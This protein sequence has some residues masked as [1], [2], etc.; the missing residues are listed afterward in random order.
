MDD[1]FIFRK[2][3]L[4]PYIEAYIS[5]ICQNLDTIYE[6]NREKCFRYAVKGQNSIQKNVELS[7][8]NANPVL[9]KFLQ[10]IKLPTISYEMTIHINPGFNRIDYNCVL[11]KICDNIFNSGYRILHGQTLKNFILNN[12]KMTIDNMLWP[13]PSIVKQST[14]KNFLWVPEDDIKSSD[15]DVFFEFW[16]RTKSLK[17]FNYES[18]REDNISF[19]FDL[20]L[21]NKYIFT[22]E[23][24]YIEKCEYP[25]Q[26][27]SKILLQIDIPTFEY[28]HSRSIMW[29]ELGN[30]VLYK[31]ILW[32][33]FLYN[34]IDTNKPNLSI[35]LKLLNVYH[36]SLN[37]F[38]MNR[39][40]GIPKTEVLLFENGERNEMTRWLKSKIYVSDDILKKFNNKQLKHLVVLLQKY[41]SQLANDKCKII[42]S[43]YIDA[44]N[45]DINQLEID[46]DI[47]FNKFLY[48]Y[49]LFFC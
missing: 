41:I 37:I 30:S 32:S 34:T 13:S 49:I 21:K 1:D 11:K 16:E 14:D 35:L 5:K 17:G 23:L 38:T 44:N 39:L 29:R 48:N 12:D 28:K 19:T 36:E 43:L 8:K 6:R 45:Q 42:I 18:T 26:T 24:P 33:N 3:L 4:I 22:L 46:L 15:Y 27:K 9:K 10:T 31:N 47:I 25:I 7:S 2:P 40:S 20:S